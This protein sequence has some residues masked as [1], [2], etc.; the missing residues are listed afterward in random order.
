MDF[1]LSDEQSLLRDTVRDFA[2]QEVAP[3]APE[4]DREKR[5]PYELVAKLGELGLM[6]IPLPEEYG[7]GGA[8]TLSYAMAIEELGRVDAS[9]AIT[10]A[11]HTSLGTLPIHRW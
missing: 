6:G 10:V 9:L 8:G 7:G 3:L 1:Q 11:A 4:L 2:R 5:F